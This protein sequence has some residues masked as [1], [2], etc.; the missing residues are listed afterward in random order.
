M[1]RDESI[2]SYYG[3]IRIIGNG[4]LLGGGKTQRSVRFETK[5]IATIWTNWHV[6]ANRECLRDVCIDGIYGSDFEP[7]VLEKDMPDGCCC[8]KYTREG[9]QA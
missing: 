3:V 2:R 7:D 9:D 8:L 6:D 5:E 1:N 4:E